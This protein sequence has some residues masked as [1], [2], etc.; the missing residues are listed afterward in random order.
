V[1]GAARGESLSAAAKWK[2]RLRV[3]EIQFGSHEDD[4][5]TIDLVN[6]N[7]VFVRVPELDELTLD[8]FDHFTAAL[9]EM[10][11]TLRRVVAERFAGG[12]Q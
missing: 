8:D 2:E 11:A 3:Y 12:P 9:V 10:G 6:D 7:R 4:K 5:V 1:S